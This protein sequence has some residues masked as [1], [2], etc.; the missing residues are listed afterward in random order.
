MKYL[1]YGSISVKSL[2]TCLTKLAAVVERKERDNLPSKFTLI[3]ELGTVSD[4]HYVSKYACFTAQTPVAYLQVMLLLSPMGDESSPDAAE[5][6]DFTIRIVSLFDR[7]LFN[8]VRIVGDN[9][10]IN[11]CI[12]N[13]AQKPLVG[14]ASYLVKFSVSNI[15]EFEMVSVAA[16]KNLMQILSKLIPA[17]KLQR[18]AHLR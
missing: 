8:V 9:C 13:L 10:N 4:T 16:V 14:C 2:M 1:R 11:K 5:H 12:A 3:F 18:H 7:S 6:L 15:S 17:A